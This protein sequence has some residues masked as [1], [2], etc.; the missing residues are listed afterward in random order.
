MYEPVCEN[1]AGDDE[2]SVAATAIVL[3]S[4]AGS[5]G[6]AAAPPLPAAAIMSTPRAAAYEIA[7]V[8]VASEPE[9]PTDMFNTRM[10]LSAA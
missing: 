1:E 8:S 4:D 2:E 7:A 6:V 3:S 9:T 5:G 10:L